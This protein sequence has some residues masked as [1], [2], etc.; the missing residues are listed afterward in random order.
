MLAS[1]LAERKALRP[2][3][4]HALYPSQFWCQVRYYAMGGGTYVSREAARAWKNRA[5]D[6]VRP[7][8]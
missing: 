8:R 6:T 5:M 4:T 2:L 1:R 7:D 3:T